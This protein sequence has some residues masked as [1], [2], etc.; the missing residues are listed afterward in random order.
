MTPVT[1]GP[2]TVRICN[3]CIYLQTHHVEW[4]CVEAICREGGKSIGVVVDRE[5][6]LV[7]EWCPF[8]KPEEA[9]NG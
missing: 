2:G 5:I 8:L 7:P 4:C 6:V 1:T 9:P 3:T